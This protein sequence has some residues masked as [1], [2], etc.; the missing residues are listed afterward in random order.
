MSLFINMGYETAL[1]NLDYSIQSSSSN[2][3]FESLFFYFQKGPFYTERVYESDFLNKFRELEL[4]SDKMQAQ[5][6]WG[7]INKDYRRVNDRRY[8]LELLN[9][10]DLNRQNSR[11]EK[12]GYQ[13]LD[14][15]I[16]KD[17]F[18][19]SGKKMNHTNLKK[20]SVVESRLDRLID[21]STF[22]ERGESHLYFNLI[23]QRYQYRGTV[24]FNQTKFQCVEHKM[25]I[26]E[27]LKEKLE[28]PFCLDSFIY[29]KKGRFLK[30]HCELN[31]RKTMGWL[32]HQLNHHFKYHKNIFTLFYLSREKHNS[33]F[34]QLTP[35]EN[36]WHAYLFG[37]DHYEDFDEL[38]TGSLNRQLMH[39]HDKA[40]RF[41]S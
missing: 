36:P 23:D 2:E 41:F 6:F 18:S 37:T 34:L 40:A 33:K 9:R 13:V 32:A 20:E 16:K 30:C 38:V 24:F 11:I 21:Y 8:F 12:K 31:Y 4:V 17:F 5:H 1:E 15:E 3:L 29:E 35:K 28:T 14:N 27:I 19:F 10:L 25:L 7:V 22:V 39:I 26:K